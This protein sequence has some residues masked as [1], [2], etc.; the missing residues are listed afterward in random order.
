MEALPGDKLR[1]AEGVHPPCLLSSPSQ[2]C[3]RKTSL[4]VHPGVSGMSCPLRVRVL[5]RGEVSLAMT[6]GRAGDHT[7]SRRAFGTR[8]VVGNGRGGGVW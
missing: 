4:Q 1:P 7:E 6:L 5:P 2:L 8:N 3:K